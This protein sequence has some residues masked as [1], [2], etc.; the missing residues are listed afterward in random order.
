V[1]SGS[2]TATFDT[3]S[4]LAYVT[5]PDAAPWP[6]AD[7]NNRAVITL[8][9]GQRYYLELDHLE[10]AGFGS[11]AAVN[12]AVAADNDTVVAPT[13]G[14]APISGAAMGWYFPQ[15]G[16]TQ[17][18]HSAGQ[19]TLAWNN[20]LGQINLGAVPFPGIAP[21]TITAS[22]PSNNLQTAETLSPASWTTLTNVSPA[23]FPTTNAMQFFRVGPQ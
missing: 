4:I 14:S 11:V 5:G 8:E 6:V 18:T 9:A 21:G 17:F 12:Y 1:V 16:I 20:P 19:V 23:S 22:F 2:D 13:I 3:N 7:A 10:N 15:P